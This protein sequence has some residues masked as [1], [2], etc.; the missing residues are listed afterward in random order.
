[1]SFVRFTISKPSRQVASTIGRVDCDSLIAENFLKHFKSSVLSPD[2][3]RRFS[4][5][6]VD[7]L[8]FG[9]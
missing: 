4:A 8:L 7:I 6:Q 2:P 9:D 1:M 3:I 5:M